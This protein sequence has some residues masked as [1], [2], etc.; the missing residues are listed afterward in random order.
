MSERETEIYEAMLWDDETTVTLKEVVQRCGVEE[1]LIQEMVEYGIIE[2]LRD[3][4]PQWQFHG[5]C[6]RR[7]TT[8]VRLQRDL[9][10]NLPGAA[11]ALDLMDQ[12]NASRGR[13]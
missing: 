1:Q 2:P 12:L 10:V 4:E 3:T 11:L 13:G 8:V 5:T 6:L 9:G 7:V